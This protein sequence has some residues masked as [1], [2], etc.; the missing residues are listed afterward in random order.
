MRSTIN[1]Y[2][3]KLLI[4]S[5]HQIDVDIFLKNKYTKK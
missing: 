3:S 2:I 5:S 4:N 1:A